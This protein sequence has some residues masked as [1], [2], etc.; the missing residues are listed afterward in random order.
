MV[1]KHICMINDKYNNIQVCEQNG[2][3]RAKIRVMETREFPGEK[4]KTFKFYKKRSRGGVFF[5]LFLNIKQYFL[6]ISVA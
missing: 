5:V 1:R 6:C 3:N 4:N 2:S